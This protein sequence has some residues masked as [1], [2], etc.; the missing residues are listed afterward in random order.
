MAKRKQLIDIDID[1]VLRDF[2]GAVY[3]YAEGDFEIEIPK[4]PLLQFSV[5][6]HLGIDNE[7]FSTWIYEERVFEIF[8]MA[9]KI[10][11]RVIDDLNF[12]AIAAVNAGYDIRIS[13]VQRNR[14]VTAT[15]HWLAKNGC[16]LQRYNFW[17][18]FEEKIANCGDIVLDDSAEVLSGCTKKRR[19]V[20]AFKQTWNESLVSSK[21]IP[22]ISVPDGST[23]GLD[24]LYEIL[25][26]PRV[27]K[28]L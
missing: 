10:Y 20:V 16:R 14:A 26:I 8:G 11:P 23:N 17:S 12:F 18:S 3:K 22:F 28:V 1:G 13:S 9:Q 5:A 2:V 27:I 21:N 4:D 6:N 25:E 24:S 19:K 7:R 15:L